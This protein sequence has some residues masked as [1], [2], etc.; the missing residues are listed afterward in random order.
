M[1]HNDL[2]YKYCSFWI[3]GVPTSSSK[4]FLETES[5]PQANDKTFFLFYKNL[6]KHS[7]APYTGQKGS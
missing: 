1:T 2:S 4:S 6:N 5:A 3:T 7:V